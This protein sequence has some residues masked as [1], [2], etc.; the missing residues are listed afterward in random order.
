M[1]HVDNDP[2]LV[3]DV[4]AAS[5]LRRMGEPEEL[6]KVNL[7]LASDNSSFINGATINVSGGL[8]MY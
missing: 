6:A 8:L 3:A 4:A 2:K 7:F 1:Q 5:P